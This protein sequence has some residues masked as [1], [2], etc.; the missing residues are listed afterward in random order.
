MK[1]LKEMDFLLNSSKTDF[2]ECLNAISLCASVAQYYCKCHLFP[3]CENY[4]GHRGYCFVCG[5]RDTYC[6]HDFEEIK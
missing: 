5:I 4:D 6:L 2:L 1:S 3:G